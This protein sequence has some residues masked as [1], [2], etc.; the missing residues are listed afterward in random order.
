MTTSTSAGYYNPVG[1]DKQRYMDQMCKRC[2]ARRGQHYSNSKITYCDR[3]D[4]RT[5]IDDRLFVHSG[6]LKDIGGK[7]YDTYCIPFEK[8]K[9]NDP[10]VAFKM[11]K[12]R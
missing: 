6:Y 10:N 8:N 5:G 2:G 4:E 9:A 11:K 7:R 12:G 1:Y 3:L